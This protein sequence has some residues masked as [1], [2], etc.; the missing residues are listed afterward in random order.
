MEQGWAT[1]GANDPTFLL[2]VKS[3]S[4]L[5]QRRPRSGSWNV[6]SSAL[7]LRDQ[8]LN[9][10]LLLLHSFIWSYPSWSLRGLI[11]PQRHLCF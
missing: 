7:H 6:A 9:P 11:L 10:S 3:P 2:P 1:A 8:D 4:H 5:L